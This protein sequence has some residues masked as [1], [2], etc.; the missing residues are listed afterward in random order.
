MTREHDELLTPAFPPDSPGASQGPAHNN[1]R[2]GPLDRASAA[3]TS[4][5]D[6][7]MAAL[8]DFFVDELGARLRELETAWSS[9]D[10][11]LLCR[12]AH[13]L[14]GAGAGYG[15]PDITRAAGELE[16]AVREQPPAMQAISQKL[17]A[18]VDLCQGVIRGHGEREPGT[19]L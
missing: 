6:R 3:K 16:D 18:L 8:V 17:Q 7:E 14:R 15:F 12:I 13:Q 19:P 5:D 1:S 2:S 9:S 11:R 10:Q 4:S